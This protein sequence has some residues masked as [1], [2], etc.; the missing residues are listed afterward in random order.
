[1]VHAYSRLKRILNAENMTVPELH[2]RLLK[3]HGSR[4]RSPAR[5]RPS[6][7]TSDAGECC[8]LELPSSQ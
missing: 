3:Q 2:R 5:C 4:R 8:L 6:G 7:S 1:M